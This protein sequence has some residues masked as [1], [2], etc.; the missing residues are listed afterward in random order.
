MNDENGMTF[1]ILKLFNY[2]KYKTEKYKM[3]INREWREILCNIT[4]SIFIT[5]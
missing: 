4:F 5:F 3:C 2:V 1:I